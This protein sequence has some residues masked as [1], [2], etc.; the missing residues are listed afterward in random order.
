M[1]NL[2]DC[3]FDNNIHWMRASDCNSFESI[4]G[5]IVGRSWTDVVAV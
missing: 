4:A 2:A 5:N 1:H 3:L